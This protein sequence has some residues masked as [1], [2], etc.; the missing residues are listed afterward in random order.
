MLDLNTAISGLRAAQ[1]GLQVASQ[2][3]TNAG[4]QGYSRQVVDFRNRSPVSVNGILIGPGVEVT[5]IRRVLDENIQS[6]LIANQGTIAALDAR[7]GIASQFELA[8]SPESG[9]IGKQLTDLYTAAKTLNASPSD[10]TVRRAFINQANR[11]AN[12]VSTAAN[13]LQGSRES[14][15]GDVQATVK[16]LNATTAEL[17]RLN[18]KIQSSLAQ[19]LAP[20]DLMDRRDVLLEKL[21]TLVD[22]KV[23][24]TSSRLDIPGLQLPAILIGNEEYRLG[25]IAPQFS[26]KSDING[27]LKLYVNDREQSINVQEGKLGG[28]LGAHNAQIPQFLDDLDALATNI[29]RI[30]D[31]VHATGV[32]S[33]SGYEQIGGSRGLTN[34]SESLQ[35]AAIP[36][37]PLRS[38][39]LFVGIVDRS[40]GTL[41]RTVHTID[42]DAST[43]SLS[44]VAAKIA[45]LPHM[46][47]TVDSARNT[48]VLSAD[49]GFGFDFTGVP[50]TQP[51]TGWT[52]T[53]PLKLSGKY[54]LNDNREI[55]LR[56]VGSG[57]IGVTP[58]LG[59][60]VLDEN[61]TLIKTLKVGPEYAPNA[62]LALRDGISVA[63]GNGTLV[64]GETFSTTLVGQPDE[65]GILSAIGVNSIFSGTTAANISVR[66]ELLA[67]PTLLSISSTG[68]P[69]DVG[70]LAKLLTA[71]DPDVPGSLLDQSSD[72]VGRAANDVADLNLMSENSN[73]VDQTLR[74]ER[75]AISGVDMDEE[76]VRMLGFQRAFQAASRIIVASDDMF[77]DLLAT[78]R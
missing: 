4:T 48:L 75:D 70:A 13:S 44:D 61:G 66:S 42:I 20:N 23:Q 71:L 65:T 1:T 47:A 69:G 6:A 31:G 2:N 30:V 12:A 36:G 59:I 57:T 11:L 67:D 28:L 7:T 63:L 52:G 64:N 15:L 26:V 17:T 27:T 43:D 56:T 62:P 3:I 33:A 74:A 21:G 72:L 73:F 35:E 38:G 78:V 50:S 41:T 76:L 37:F 46:Q 68:Q 40:G 49:S 16:Q 34:T 24:Y 18:S 58:G 10:I 53:A 25:E 19:N 55:T 77:N 14:L 51:T 60:Q 22:A 5:R 32:P 29:M 54:S 9:G 39:R 8:L 45:A